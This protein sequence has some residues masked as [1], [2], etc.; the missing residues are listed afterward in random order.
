[1]KEKLP[2]GIPDP[3][4]HCIASGL[5]ARYC[6]VSEAYLSGIGKELQDLLG[7]GDA[8][9]RDWQADRAGVD[10]ARSAKDDEQLAACCTDRGY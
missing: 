1:M 7:K 10:C 8:D 4:A 3:R 2:A 6:S 5:I 9:W